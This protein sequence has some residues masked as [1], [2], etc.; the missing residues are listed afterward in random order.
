M[1]PPQGFSPFAGTAMVQ[2]PPQQQQQQHG[3]G[4][5]SSHYYNT[6]NQQ[7]QS[8]QKM[9]A[10]APLHG[11]ASWVVGGSSGPH[12]S[13]GLKIPVAAARAQYGLKPVAMAG[14]AAPLSLL[15]GKPTLI[16]WGR[17]RFL[18]MDAPRVRG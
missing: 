4:S 6:T 8:R 2:L 9:H 13:Y 5:H 15:A 10:H 18:I 3:D 1:A 17:L 14:A 12:P 11:G 16:A 7:Q